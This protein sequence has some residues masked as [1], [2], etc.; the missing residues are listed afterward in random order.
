[1]GEG[2]VW[3]GSA[4]GGESEDSQEGTGTMWRID[5][6]TNE[7]VATIPLPD[8]VGYLSVA[9]GAGAVWL[10]GGN[11][12]TVFQI[13]PATNRVTATIPA[14][15]GSVSFG[16]GSLWV[17]SYQAPTVKRIDPNT[18]DVLATIQGR[19]GCSIA[20]GAG[21]VWGASRTVS[22]R[23]RRRTLPGKPLAD[24]R[25]EGAVPVPRARSWRDPSGGTRRDPTSPSGH[26]PDPTGLAVGLRSPLVH[27]PGVGTEKALTPDRRQ[28][29]QESRDGTMRKMRPQT[30]DN[31]YG[32]WR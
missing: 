11:P 29:V 14:P 18:G 4:D 17:A 28:N 20:I 19:C 6:D 9:T 26:H 10:Q 32:Y 23:G 12:S 13:D 3:I 15:L 7:V 1:M 22:N 21:G 31:A 24:R 8:A 2:A 16:R 5:P 27:V 30:P 25:C